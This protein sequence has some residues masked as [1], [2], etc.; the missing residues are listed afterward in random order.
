LVSK[1]KAQCAPSYADEF[2]S[3][4]INLNKLKEAVLNTER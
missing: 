1:E 3:R 4:E 2:F